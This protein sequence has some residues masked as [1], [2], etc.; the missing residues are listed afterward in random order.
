MSNKS[1]SII[2][3]IEERTAVSYDVGSNTVSFSGRGTSTEHFISLFEL[4]I[5]K[6]IISETDLPFSARHAQTRYII[7]NEPSHEN[8]EMI[9]PYEI[10]EEVYL[11]TN[12]DTDSKKRYCKKAIEDFVLG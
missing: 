7:N 12:H 9:R 8:R 1:Q 3:T 2:S 4:L 11:E 5:E 10:S 6:D